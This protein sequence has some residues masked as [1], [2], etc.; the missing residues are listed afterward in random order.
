VSGQA[1]WNLGRYDEAMAEYKAVYGPDDVS[2]KA[3]ETALARSGPQA[4]LRSR[5]EFL[6][7]Q[8]DAP[9]S[10][11][12]RAAD[13]GADVAVAFAEPAALNPLSVATA[14]AEAAMADCAFKWLDVAYQAKNAQI[15]HVAVDPAYDPV[16]TDPRYGELMRKL[17]LPIQPR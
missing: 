1:L 4:A 2:F 9:G 17:A 14:C 11:G 15:L 6:L 12:P 5:A 10:S 7:H 8:A 16:R 13:R 3:F